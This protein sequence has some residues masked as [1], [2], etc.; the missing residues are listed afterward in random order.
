MA[1]PKSFELLKNSLEM[2]PGVGEKTAERYVYS[3][4]KRNIEDIINLSDALINFKK[5]IKRCISCNCLSDDELCSI[6]SDKDRNH[7]VIC[8]VEDSKTVFS[9]ERTNKYTG[10]FFVLN[11]LISPIDGVNPEDLNLSKLINKIS[12]STKE[13]IIALNPSI[14]GEVTSLYIQKKL[15][16]RNLKI[17][18]LSYGI[19]MGGDIDYLDPIMISK[20]LDDRKTMS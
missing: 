7:S 11:G 14:E 4:E 17:S 16:N 13:I 10:E 20:A 19:P 6:C 8:I 15:E 18:R 1:V 3:L 9:I 12:S 5:N 2:L